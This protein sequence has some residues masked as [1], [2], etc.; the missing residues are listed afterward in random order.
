MGKTG[1][2]YAVKICMVVYYSNIIRWNA[3]ADGFF[4]VSRLKSSKVEIFQ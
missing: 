3:I 4:A 2:D 1:E